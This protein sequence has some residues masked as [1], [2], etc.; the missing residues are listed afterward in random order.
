[1]PGLGGKN[2]YVPV[3]NKCVKKSEKEGRKNKNKTKNFSIVFYSMTYSR[4][5]ER[6]GIGITKMYRYKITFDEEIIVENIWEI[7]KKVTVLLDNLH[8]DSTKL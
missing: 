1:M 7:G 5:D 3:Q 4:A 2:V 8:R 6:G